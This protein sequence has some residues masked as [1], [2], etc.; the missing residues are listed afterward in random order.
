VGRRYNIGAEGDGLRGARLSE[1][2]A[3]SGDVASLQENNTSMARKQL[4]PFFL[5]LS[6]GAQ[7]Q[8]YFHIDEIAVWPPDPTTSENVSIYL[9]GNLSD[10]GAYIVSTEA[11]AGVG[12]VDLTVVATSDGG[13]TILVPHTETIQLGQLPSGTYTIAFTPNSVGIYDWASPPE[14]TFTVSDGGGSVCDSLAL[15]SMQWAA[16]SDTAVVVH[17]QNNSMDLFDYPNFILFNAQGDTL[18]KESVFFFGIGNES[19]HSMRVMDGVTMPTSS[20]NGRLELWTGFTSSLACAWDNTFDLCPPSPCATMYPTLQNWGGALVIGTFDW[21]IYDGAD[22]VA[23]GQFV[24]TDLVQE[25]TDSICLPP[26]RYDMNVV[27]N[28]PSSGGWPVF[29][30]MAPGSQSSTMQEVY[31]PLPV[32]LPIEFYLPCEDSSN[33]IS[34]LSQGELHVICRPDGMLV[35]RSDG[36]P[37][38]NVWLFDA[39][40]RMLF[41]TQASTDRLFVPISK[42]G[43]YV[44]RA[45]DRVVKLFGGME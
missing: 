15:V 12:M 33:D 20:F 43:V 30:A 16:F 23:S 38:G 45:N 34:E 4:L 41:N 10:G 39:Q 36:Q 11:S 35:T 44:L 18:A 32:L 40:G 3:F 28:Q 31:S 14:H 1:Q 24:M 2:A 25:A 29:G 17:V 42:P 37:L 7:A 8:T 22:L 21:T 19:W 27:A 26:G 5:V 9:I 6:F 13:F